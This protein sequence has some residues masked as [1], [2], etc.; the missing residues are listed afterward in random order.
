LGFTSAVPLCVQCP[1]TAVPPSRGLDPPGRRH[2]RARSRTDQSR[3]A[4]G[5]HRHYSVWVPLS[6][7]LY[8]T[9]LYARPFFA[10]SRPGMTR[11]RINPKVLTVDLEW[12]AVLLNLET[13][14]Y[15]H[16]NDAGV[17]VWRWLESGQGRAAPGTWASFMEA[18]SGEG[19]VLPCD[20]SVGDAPRNP[21]APA[22]VLGTPDLRRHPAPTHGTAAALSDCWRLPRLPRSGGTDPFVTIIVPARN[23]EAT[24]ADCL[25]SLLAL[26]FPESRR[27]IVVVDNA[28]N[29]RTSDVIRGLPVRVVQERQRGASSARNRGIEVSRGDIIA[30]TDADCVVTRTWLRELIEGFDS[31]EV[32][33]VAGEI[34]AFPPVSAAERYMAKRL[35]RWQHANLSAPQPSIVTASVAFRR[36][37]FEHVGLFDPLLTRA[38]DTDFGWR[39]LRQGDW[40][41]R[42][43]PRA[44]VLHRHRTTA[45]QFFLHQARWGYG[46][47]LIGSK[48]TLPSFGPRGLRSWGALVAQLNVLLGAGWRALRVRQDR[49]ELEEAYF[50]LLR[51]LGRRMGVL[52]WLVAGPRLPSAASTPEFLQQR[53]GSR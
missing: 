26:D 9:D 4:A 49:E 2:P 10:G 15:Y 40:Q 12:R 20:D 7:N 41:L 5:S 44:I 52:A 37:V 43:R 39:F 30:F 36:V 47:A 46:G 1:P 3:L 34:M 6:H 14:A 50:E 18:L 8:A 24:I 42:Y 23:S 27:E 21:P 11:L 32:G 45:T 19:L 29:D 35:P 53:A 51:L 17:Q 33:G 28:S 22:H 13:A 25:T 31:A 48:Y 38:Q 16:L